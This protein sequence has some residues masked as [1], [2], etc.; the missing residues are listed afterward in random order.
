MTAISKTITVNPANNNVTVEQTI[1]PPAV[2]ESVSLFGSSLN[3]GLGWPVDLLI[4]VLV[5]IALWSGKR[6]LETY[7]FSKRR[8]E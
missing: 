1:S 8:K 4:L 7:F 6:C 5:V 3:S 2:N